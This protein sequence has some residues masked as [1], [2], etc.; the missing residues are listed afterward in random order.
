MS[1]RS[2]LEEYLVKRG[3]YEVTYEQN[4]VSGACTWTCTVTVNVDHQTSVYKSGVC[5]VKK[6]AL[7]DACNRAYAAIIGRSGLAQPVELPRQPAESQTHHP[8][9]LP[10]QAAGAT[11]ILFVDLESVQLSYEQFVALG[12][13]FRIHVVYSKMIP[14]T[15][16][17]NRYRDSGAPINIRSLDSALRSAADVAICVEVGRFLERQHIAKALKYE[18]KAT[19]TVLSKDHFASAL[20][21]YKVRH[22]T[23]VEDL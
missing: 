13:R 11:D 7:H 6:K 17:L 9:S 16:A 3:S 10:Q 20:E 14:S 23:R 2:R 4:G 12:E 15:E 19:I 18:V 22:V 21:L 8:P 5:D 1:S